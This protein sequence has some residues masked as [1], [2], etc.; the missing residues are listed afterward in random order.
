MNSF[1]RCCAM[2]LESGWC[3]VSLSYRV[4]DVELMYVLFSELQS[5]K[6]HLNGY[7]TFFIFKTPM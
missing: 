3:I 7:I 4:A 6:G 2:E 5:R 1:F